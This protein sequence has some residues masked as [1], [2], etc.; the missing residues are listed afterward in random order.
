MDPESSA[1]QNAA[2]QATPAGAQ[3]AANETTAESAFSLGQDQ[4]KGGA[5]SKPKPGVDKG[6]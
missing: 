3:A 2:D 1:Y 4:K 5:A 6:D